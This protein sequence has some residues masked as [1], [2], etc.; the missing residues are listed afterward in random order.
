MAL[1]N[2]SVSLRA[3]SGD[4]VGRRHELQALAAAFADA[5]HGQPRCVLVSGEAGVG[6]SRLTAEFS[7]ECA[8]EDALWLAGG[9][10]ALAGRDLPYGPLLEALRGA[11]HLP[12]AAETAEELARFVGGPGSEEDKAWSPS[13]RQAARGQVFELLL[14]L[15][16]QVSKSHPLVLVVED[17]HWADRSTLDVLLFLT[18]NLT[19]ERMLLI[20]TYRSDEKG[21]G[22][23]LA[24]WLGEQRRQ[25]RVMHVEL[26]RFSHSEVKAQLTNLLSHE[27]EPRLLD[28][29]LA[30]SDGN[31]FYV[32]ELIAAVLQGRRLSSS[33]QDILSAKLR[34]LPPRTQKLLRIAAVA[35]RSF[36]PELLGDLAS[37]GDDE[38]FESLHS[39]T[40]HHV[41]LPE[42]ENDTLS[43]RH[44]L[45]Q[46]AAY[47]ELL[48]G[49]RERLHARVATVLS[50]RP[51]LGIQHDAG[52]KAEISHHWYAAGNHVRALESAIL[53]GKAAEKAHAFNETLVQFERSVEL[54]D[55]VPDARVFTG[56][57]LATVLSRAAEAAWAIGHPGRAV[58]LQQNAVA[59]VDEVA[60]PLR[61]GMFYERLAYYIPVHLYG[62]GQVAAAALEKAL[63]LIPSDKPSVERAR[64]LIT[65]AD[66]TS[67]GSDYARALPFAEEG[68]AIAALVGDKV[69]RARALS[70]LGGILVSLGDAPS[71]VAHVRE[72]VAVARELDS[73]IP[74]LSALS[75][76]TYVLSVAG[77]SQ[78][79]VETALEAREVGKKT[80]ITRSYVVACLLNAAE[81]LFELG[82]WEEA[83]RLL[84]ELP[85]SLEPV[86]GDFLPVS[87]GLLETGRGKFASAAKQ[88]A[89]ASQRLER[90]SPV[91]S[92]QLQRAIAELAW[93]RGDLDEA[94][95]IVDRGLQTATGTG[96]EI[97]TGALLMIGLRIEAD[98]AERA[99]A[100]RNEDETKEAR[101]SGQ[102]LV[103]T[104]QSFVPNPLDARECG[105]PETAA[106]AAT[107]QA[108][109]SRLE[110]I[111][112]AEQWAAAAQEWDSLD[113]PYPGAYCHWREAEAWLLSGQRA[114]ATEALRKGHDVALRLGALPLLE[115]V[116]S[117]ARRSRLDLQP[118]AVISQDPQQQQSPADSFGLTQRELEVL[119]HLA[120]GATN[121]EIGRALFISP[122]TAGVHVSNI[123][124]KLG[125]ENRVEA[126][127]AAYRLGLTPDT[128]SKA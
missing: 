123:L 101:A 114:K 106:V 5:I 84:E 43:F 68:A 48:P 95:A 60:E 66:V 7:K 29:I 85:P 9:C 117:L 121:A 36:T 65:L 109:W 44:A 93:W 39:A 58:S 16:A 79:V 59:A 35:G 82:R 113:R 99:C 50:R 57:D 53:A 112:D 90:A 92:L 128:M 73:P 97:A 110:G 71:G 100:R 80:G 75:W 126:A 91:L 122:R 11:R 2:G 41:L 37:I 98:R 102:A 1:N 83:H 120:G 87:L 42:P 61:A 105:L 103:Q 24:T 38:L 20:L 27:P 14:R 116:E 26:S 13:D 19:S 108:E 81:A 47:M 111:Q 23:S 15:L 10:V 49:E 55:R 124:R 54:W 31:P 70:H 96:E 46:E 28:E 89:I 76:A 63:R 119:V 115:R 17:I 107:W 12:M 32:E 88:L 86:Y 67:A 22:N 33:L 125:V 104:A 64:V 34:A 69:E 77:Q 78:Q 72:A 56:M 127:T 51:E 52:I 25:S 30:R 21:D 18:R 3:S 94:R 40:D 4:F 45:L 8:R 74:L 118:P 6:K 62:Q